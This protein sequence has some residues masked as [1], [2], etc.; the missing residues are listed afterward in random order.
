[1]MILIE[2]ET[3]IG[4][5]WWK[6]MNVHLSY[7][8]VIWLGF[9]IVTYSWSV[10]L[11]SG[12]IL[13]WIILWVYPARSRLLYIPGFHLVNGRVPLLLVYGSLNSYSSVCSTELCP[14][15]SVK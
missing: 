9:I 11:S 2:L 4:A 7:L 10:S 14:S 15:C 13:G 1:M 5:S 8:V 6:T 3:E 12:S